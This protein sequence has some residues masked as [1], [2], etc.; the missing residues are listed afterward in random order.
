MNGSKNLAFRYRLDRCIRVAAMFIMNRIM[1]R[2]A[3]ATVDLRRE[4][5]DRILLVRGVFRLGNAI[6]AIPSILL[7]RRNFPDARID[8]IG[9]SAAKSLF[10]NLP[11]DHFYGIYHNYLKASWSYLILLA[12]VRAQKYDLAVDVSGSSTAMGAF[13]VG[14]SGARWRAGLAGKWDRWFNL[15]FA[16]SVSCNKYDSMIHL[17]EAMGLKSAICYP[18]VTLL[19]DELA[20]GSHRAGKL[21][22]GSEGLMVG[23]FVGGRRVRGKRWAKE[24]FLQLA[25]KLNGR[26]IQVLIFVGPEELEL[27]A[28]F[29]GEVGDRTKVIF[30]PD[31]R[32]FA[33]L[34]SACDLFVA[35]D[36]GPVHLA[37]ALQLRTVAIFLHK[38]F[39]RWGPPAELAQIVYD[40]NGVSAEAVFDAC[41]QELWPARTAAVIE[42]RVGSVMTIARQQS[43]DVEMKLMPR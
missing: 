36:S 34:I 8:F 19:P 21:L 14:A 42:N 16:R 4:K 3:P 20:L 2:T 17:V 11:I 23:L 26:G 27:A 28:Y 22:G 41:L 7:F 13:I 37:C 18:R 30:E 6:L 32:R 31:L 43:C 10:I 15:R 35:C 5:I 40:P 25:L 9:G 24:N 12:K 1:P 39:D 33:A 29:H 38:D